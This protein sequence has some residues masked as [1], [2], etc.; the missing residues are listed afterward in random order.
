MTKKITLTIHFLVHI[1]I[2]QSSDGQIPVSATEYLSKKFLNYCESVP[3]EEIYIHS[4]RE[5]FIAGENLWFNIYLIDRQSFKPSKK[6]RIAYFELLNPDNRPVIQKR[7]LISDGLGPGQIAIPDTLSTGTYTIRAYTSWMKNFLPYNCFMKDIKV[8]NALSNKAFKGKSSTL[9]ISKVE[10]DSLLHKSIISFGLTFK[11]NNLKPDSLEI[12]VKSDQKIRSE[13]NNI[14]YLF[15]QTHGRIDYIRTQ[16]LSGDIT[17]IIVPKSVLSSGI[18]QITLFDSEI[19]PVGERLIYTPSKEFPFLTLN[20][21]DT[22]YTRNK[23]SLEIEIGTGLSTLMNKTDISISVAPE[24]NMGESMNIDDYMVFGSEFGL[25]N[26]DKCRNLIM[27]KMSPLF[28]DSLLLTMKSNWLDWS[29]ILRGALPSFKY[30]SEKEDHYLLGTLLTKDQY[31]A[32]KDEYIL[33]ST[34]GKVAMFQYVRTDMEGN[35]SFR[36][37]IDERLKDLL[38]QP[39]DIDKYK[40]INLGSSFSDRYFQSEISVDS[41]CKPPSYISKWSVN[42]QVQKIYGSSSTGDPLASVIQYRTPQRFYGKPD[43]ELIMD[44]YIKLP[45]MEEV[46]FELMAGVLIKKKKSG[47]EISITDPVDNSP[48]EVPP[49]LLIDGVI[50]KDPLIIVNLDPDLVE[51]IDVVRGEYIVGDY[52]CFGIINLITKTADF[53]S[54]TLPDYAIRLPYRVIDPVVSFVSPDYSSDEMKNSRI[55]DFRNTLY[56][57]SSILPDKNGKAKV[58]FWSSDIASVY[59]VNIQGITSEG[60]M[61]STSK[62]IRI[63]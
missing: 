3:R 14:T 19:H 37:H 25:I 13:D 12:I 55:P 58:E 23:I 31:P 38:I 60:K 29:I 46:F 9:N 35:F 18:N 20:S 32:D 53:R 42:Y 5:E 57:N 56:W 41:S 21:T 50:I 10:T 8:Y 40:I 59:M 2:L 45:V 6:S 27:G 33:L 51:K 30:K 44:D 61:F 4:D 17:N 48:Y 62:K 28:I 34:P 47:Y 22:G 24:T 1:L 49:V 15:I 11:V 26:Q 36:I 39:D 54:V 52:K 7:I 16:R 43:I 63:E